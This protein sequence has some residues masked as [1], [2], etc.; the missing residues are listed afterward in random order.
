MALVVDSANA[1]IV[2]GETKRVDFGNVPGVPAAVRA[3]GSPIGPLRFEWGIPITKV[4]PTDRSL[5][6]EFTIGNFF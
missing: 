6:F 5:I 1:A 3:V 4:R 2:V